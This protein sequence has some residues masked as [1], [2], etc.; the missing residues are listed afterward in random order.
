MPRRAPEEHMGSVVLYPKTFLMANGAAA[1]AETAAG[2]TLEAVPRLL[3]PYFVPHDLCPGMPMR[4]RLVPDP[5]RGPGY[6]ILELHDADQPDSPVF[7]LRRASDGAWLSGTGWR[8]TETALRPEAWNTDGDCPRLML[9]ADIVGALKPDDAYVLALPGTGACALELDARVLSRAIGGK[10]AESPHPAP[11]R[12][13]RLGCALL[14]LLLFAAWLA[15][16]VAL[17][18]GS[19]NAPATP[20]PGAGAGD[21]AEESSFSLFPRTDPDGEPTYEQEETPKP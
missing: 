2:K 19:M 10:D 18:H 9:G 5:H 17:W 15:G 6:A 12:R 14:G 1:S 3:L 8:Q 13:K 4:A 20:A 16:G 7:L 21:T 11:A